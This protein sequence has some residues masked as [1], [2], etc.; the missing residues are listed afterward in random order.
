MLFPGFRVVVGRHRFPS[1]LS[2]THAGVFQAQRLEDL[3]LQ[4]V[5]VSPAADTLHDHFRQCK[6]VVAVNGHCPRIV[7]ETGAGQRFNRFLLDTVIVFEPEGIRSFGP[8]QARCVV[9]GHSHGDLLVPIVG[10]PEFRKVFHDRLIERDLALVDQQHDRRRY[11]YLAD[12][13]DIE[14]RGSLNGN[15]FFTIG[16]AEAFRI[17][18]PAVNHDGGSGTPAFAAVYGLPDLA[19]GSGHCD[20]V[21]ISAPEHLG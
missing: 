7:L 12:G 11:I 18:D 9:Q 8:R 21:R 5:N 19:S 14:E 20:F 3:P 6:A 15:A 1:D 13:A 17:N 2:D 10:H 16:H 4:K